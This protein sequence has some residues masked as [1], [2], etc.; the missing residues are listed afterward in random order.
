MIYLDSSVALAQLLSEDRRPPLDLWE[1]PLVSSRLLEFELLNV[2][3][4]HALVGSHEALARELL[5]RVG[6][7]ELVPEVVSNA[8]RSAFA[9][10]TLDSLHLASALFLLAQGV[11]LQLASY[12]TRMVEAARKLRIP[13][14]PL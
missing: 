9:L 6:L 12:D 13:V 10:R 7:L 1:N 4:A 14:L 3:H 8:R 11:D 2:L 5:T